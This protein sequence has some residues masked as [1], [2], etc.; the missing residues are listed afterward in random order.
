MPFSPDPYQTL[1]PY[2][3]EEWIK[4]AGIRDRSWAPLPRAGPAHLSRAAGESL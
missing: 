3:T 1:D 2:Q 4:E